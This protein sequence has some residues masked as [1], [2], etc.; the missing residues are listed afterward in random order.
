[1]RSPIGDCLQI[2]FFMD[3]VNGYT[4]CKA[5]TRDD[6]AN[7]VAGKQ[8]CFRG[9]DNPMDPPFGYEWCGCGQAVYVYFSVVMTLDC[10]YKSANRL[11][12]LTGCFLWWR[13][14]AHICKQTTACVQMGNAVYSGA[15]A[16]DTLVAENQFLET[17][18]L[19]D[20]VSPVH[21]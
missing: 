5:A 14:Y 21:Y 19:I 1:M 8:Y 15:S 10:P 2:D 12:E 13:R 3:C 17:C 7:R 4:G 18:C 16:A 9:K 6:R 20:N 11:S